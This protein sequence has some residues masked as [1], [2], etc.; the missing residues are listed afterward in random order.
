MALL[1]FLRHASRVSLGVAGR[2]GL[3]SGRFGWRG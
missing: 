3:W 1:F 2:G